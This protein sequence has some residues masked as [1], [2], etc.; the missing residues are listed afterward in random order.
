MIALVTATWTITIMP[1]LALAD[2]PH[3]SKPG[4]PSCYNVDFAD[5]RADAQVNGRYR[6]W[7][8]HFVSNVVQ[9]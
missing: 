4:Y 6:H 8:K 7:L 5:G 9:T 2:P 1:K 3:C